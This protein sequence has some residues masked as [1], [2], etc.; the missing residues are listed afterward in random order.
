MRSNFARRGLDLL[1]Q[2]K[3]CSELAAQR[4]STVD[5]SR[6][7][8]SLPNLFRVRCRRNGF[9]GRLESAPNLARRPQEHHV[10]SGLR[11]SEKRGAVCARHTGDQPQLERLS[12]THAQLADRGTKA[13]RLESPRILCLFAQSHRG[14]FLERRL[15]LPTLP[16]VRR[17]GPLLCVCLIPLRAVGVETLRI[18]MEETG[19][20]VEVS[21]RSLL[22]GRDDEEAQFAPLN[23]SR[24]NVRRVDG[25]LEIN[26]ALW[27]HE[28]VRFRLSD[29]DSEGSIRA[30]GFTVRGD[31]VVRLHSSRLQLINVLPL[32]EYLLGVVGAEMPPGFPDEAL[33]AQAVAARTYALRKKLDAA[34]P[35]VHLGASV[36]HQVYRGLSRADERVRQAIEATRGEI[37]TFNLEPI[38]AYF[39]AS[40]GG[41]TEAGQPALSRDLP[42]LRSVECPCG[43]LASNRWELSISA[44]ELHPLFGI[45]DGDAVA[46]SARS[47]TGRVKTL[48]LGAGRSLDAVEFRQKLGYDRV[49]SLWFELERGADGAIRIVGRGYGHGA[50]LCQRGAKAFAD[51]GRSYR[52]ILLHYYP[53]I[54]IQQLY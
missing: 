27:D 6:Q 26:G 23:L 32:E 3:Q 30:R 49:K 2:A 48:S 17:I 20:T 4:C 36:L 51:Q 21:G 39:H 24:A 43:K 35:S 50:G 18:A 54:E 12:A 1:K 10:E 11:Y 37:L 14:R 44:A 41:R 53:G 15:A 33:K 25:Q 34:D 52:D 7:Q 45:R 8:R 22:F 29:N 40:C 16:S 19:S 47:N 38:E 42:Y 9:C 46:I 13:A 5:R 28:A 31:V